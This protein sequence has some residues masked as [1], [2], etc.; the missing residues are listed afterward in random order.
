MTHA[1]AWLQTLAER[2]SENREHCNHC[3]A[4]YYQWAQSRAAQVVLEEATLQA[5]APAIGRW[6]HLVTLWYRNSQYF[7]LWRQ[8]L[9]EN[10]D[11]FE[12]FHEAGWEP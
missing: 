10:R 2:L 5:I 11:P 6:E 8:A 12:A 4:C 7:R 1:E 9:Q 3:A